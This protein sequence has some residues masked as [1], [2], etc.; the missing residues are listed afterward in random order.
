M[1]Q[2]ETEARIGLLVE[3]E[4]ERLGYE[5]VRVQLAGA[6]RGLSLQIMAERQDRRA[7]QV[8]D[9]AAITRAL[10]ALLEEADIIPGAY[11]LEVSSPG[12]DRPLTRE[13][14]YRDW[15]GFEAKIELKQMLN[16]RKNY[17]GVLGGL[18]DGM[19]LM[20]ADGQDVALPFAGIAKARLI[21]TDALM[22]A[23]EQ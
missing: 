21:L 10:D 4:I 12:I 13:K 23:V 3:P 5:L 8:E 16:G 15:A 19:V 18:Q 22:K 20:Q 11:A 2:G 14:D 17:R 6:S 1:E 7:M 9:C